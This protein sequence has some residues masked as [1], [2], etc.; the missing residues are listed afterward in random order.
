MIGL[1]GIDRGVKMGQNSCVNSTQLN[2]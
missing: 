1:L 2:P